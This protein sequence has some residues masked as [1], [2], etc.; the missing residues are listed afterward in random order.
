MGITHSLAKGGQGI[1]GGTEAL[2]GG[3]V[4]LEPMWAGSGPSLVEVMGQ[5]GCRLTLRI[6]PGSGIDVAGVVAAFLGHTG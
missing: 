5:Q 1:E 6:L 3:F 4:E 2:G